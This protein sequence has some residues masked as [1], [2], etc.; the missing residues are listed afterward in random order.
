LGGKVLDVGVDR[1]EGC[2]FCRP[3]GELE[4]FTVSLFRQTVAELVSIAGL[5]LILDLTGVTFVDSAGL[6]ALIGGIRRVRECGGQVVVA[7]PRRRLA[8]LLHTTGLD[9]IVP[10]YGSAGDAAMAFAQAVEGSDGE[11][12]RLVDT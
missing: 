11:A 12:E 2:T 10:I 7:C 1:S 3:V 6:G 8:E 4:A 9:R 5:A